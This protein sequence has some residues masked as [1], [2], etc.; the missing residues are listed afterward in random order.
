MGEQNVVLVTG[1]NKGIGL[2]IGRQLG[3]LGWAVILLAATMLIITA[4]TKVVDIRKEL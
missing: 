4:L 1:G 3:Q 2:D